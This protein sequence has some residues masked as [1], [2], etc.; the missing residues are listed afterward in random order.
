VTCNGVGSEFFGTVQSSSENRQSVVKVWNEDVGR[1][2]GSRAVI[3]VKHSINTPVY[4]TSYRESP[5]H[6]RHLM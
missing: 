5:A 1:G 4:I 3:D 6:C 2:Y